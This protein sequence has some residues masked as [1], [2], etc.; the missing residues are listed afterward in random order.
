MSTF[1]TQARNP[2]PESDL[3][4]ALN[5]ARKPAVHTWQKHADEYGVQY[6]ATF[7]GVEVSV[8]S[9]HSDQT[10]EAY[11]HFG[12][13]E[14]PEDVVIGE[15]QTVADAMRLAEGWAKQEHDREMDAERELDAISREQEA[16]YEAMRGEGWA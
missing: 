12:D 6:L 1:Q 13:I 4:K 2:I 5:E 9:D 16:A 14:N 11:A 10:A 3:R 8:Y 15:A 7:Y